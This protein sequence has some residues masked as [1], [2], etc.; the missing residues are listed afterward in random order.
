MYK[1]GRQALC[2]TVHRGWGSCGLLTS[3][4]TRLLLILKDLGRPTTTGS[5]ESSP[6]HRPAVRETHG[7][8][9]YAIIHPQTCSVSLVLD[10]TTIWP[11]WGIEKKERRGG[12]GWRQCLRATLTVSSNADCTGSVG[13]LPTSANWFFYFGGGKNLTFQIHEKL[14]IEHLW[15]VGHCS[16]CSKD[17][18]IKKGPFS[19][20]VY[21]IVGRET[22]NKWAR[23][24]ELNGLSVKQLLWQKG[25]GECWAGLWGGVLVW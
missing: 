5:K 25:A 21:I 12:S 4:L 9:E 19:P 3:R 14:C 23:L 2:S 11:A 18:C 13:E 20:D 15:H 10:K 7:G 1:K 6:G 24:K 16:R 17:W 22:S 8:G